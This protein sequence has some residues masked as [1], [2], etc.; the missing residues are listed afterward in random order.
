LFVHAA[1]MPLVIWV[2]SYFV[3]PRTHA[4]I[5]SSAAPL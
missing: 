2:A 5:D 1:F 4:E 3:A